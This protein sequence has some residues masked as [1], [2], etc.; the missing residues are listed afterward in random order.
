MK[1]LGSPGSP[2]VLYTMDEAAAHTSSEVLRA[3][4][5]CQADFAAAVRALRE[6]D[7]GGFR[8]RMSR[9]AASPHGELEHEFCLARWEL[10][11]G[12]PVRP[13]AGGPSK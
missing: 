7:E 9:S 13:F 2:F 5:Q 8:S 3:R 6:A 12:F 1:I 11:K 10:E 4:C